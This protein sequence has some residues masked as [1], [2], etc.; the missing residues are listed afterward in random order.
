[1]RLIRRNDERL[2]L[3]APQDIEKEREYYPDIA[4]SI[5]AY[6]QST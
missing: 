3:R 1:M 4:G 6:Q 5:L 2:S